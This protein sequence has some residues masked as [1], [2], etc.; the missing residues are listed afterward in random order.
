MG[1]TNFSTA[2]FFNNGNW[3][4]PAGVNMVNVQS[5]KFWPP[6]V[7]ET[8]GFIDFYGRAW[9]SGGPNA[10]GALGNNAIATVSSPVLVVGGLNFKKTV[11][12][13]AKHSSCGLATNGNMYGWGINDS[14]QV[15]DG[16][17]AAKSSPVLVVGGL[18]F[19]DFETN[20]WANVV[21]A[22]STGGNLYAWG[23]NLNGE[24]GDSS[25]TPKSSPVLV[26]GGLIWS[27]V[28]RPVGGTPSLTGNWVVGLDVNGNCYGWGINANGQLGDGTVTPRSSPVLVVG[29]LT[30][31]DV[32]GGGSFPSSSGAFTHSTTGLTTAGVAYGWGYNGNGQLGDG[33]ITTRSSP[34]LVIGGLTF[35]KIYAKPGSTSVY[36]LTTTGQLY[37]WGLNTDGQLGDG[38][39]VGKSSPVLVLGGLTFASVIQVPCLT[40]LSAQSTAMFGITADGTLYAWGANATTAGGNGWLGVGDINPRSSPV[41]VLGGLGGAP[42]DTTNDFNIPVTPG[43]TYAI[44]FGTNG[45]SFG[46]TV[47]GQQSVD[48]VLL[49]WAT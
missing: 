12:S 44:A 36:G 35:A 9:G 34:V 18:A 10:N 26:V 6:G 1:K 2:S 20:Q 21:Y 23:S 39:I 48:S 32:Q 31:S 7:F 17:T 8:C 47:I 25:T 16:T 33:T 30:F 28:I 4:C 15:G 41:Q 42:L 29:G 11:I 27:K 38:T 24:I 13:A 19:L 40:T 43:T 14:G 3:V 46:G 49:T 37:G 22:R 45:V 5:N